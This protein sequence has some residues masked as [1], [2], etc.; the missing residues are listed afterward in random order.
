MK[1]KTPI[2]VK[3]LIKN[4]ASNDYEVQNEQTEI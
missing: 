4:M 3:A 1:S 2:E